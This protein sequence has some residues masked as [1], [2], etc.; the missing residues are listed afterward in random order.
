MAP[1]DRQAV[2]PAVTE[3]LPGAQRW[4]PPPGAPPNVMGGHRVQFFSEEEPV[5]GACVPGGQPVHPVALLLL[6]KACA[7]QGVQ[8][9]AFAAEKVPGAQGAHRARPPATRPYAPAWQGAQWPAPSLPLPGAQ[10]ATVV[11][12]VGGGVG[13][14]EPL[15]LAVPDTVPVPL[16]VAVPVPELLPVPLTVGVAVKVGVWEELGDDVN[17]PVGVGLEDWVGV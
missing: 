6:L 13:V 9:D 17:V 14:G 11:V 4:H 12:G 15:P 2:E 5:A 16:G 10:G 8:E 3:M 7:A 1:V